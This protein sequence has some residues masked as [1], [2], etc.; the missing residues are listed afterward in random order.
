MNVNI[1]Y[2]LSQVKFENNEKEANYSGLNNQI[3]SLKE[4]VALKNKEIEELN[5]KLKEKLYFLSH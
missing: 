2:E 4:T 5:K 1:N 3:K